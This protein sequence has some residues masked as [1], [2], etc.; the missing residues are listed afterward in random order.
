MLASVVLFN[1]SWLS[2]SFSFVTT[3]ARLSKFPSRVLTSPLFP[4]C[5]V[6]IGIWSSG[7]AAELAAPNLV[8][9]SWAWALTLA[10]AWACL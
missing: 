6:S 9:P 4:S 2:T 5:C 3:A 1:T 10:L 7:R 8:L